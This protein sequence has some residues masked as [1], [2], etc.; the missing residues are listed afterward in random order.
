MKSIR[1]IVACIWEM[2]AEFI[3]VL[4]LMKRPLQMPRHGWEVK[5]KVTL[6][7]GLIY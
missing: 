7:L 2:R 5:V 4:K 6:S 1:V 3:L